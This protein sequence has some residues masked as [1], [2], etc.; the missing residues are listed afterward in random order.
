MPSITQWPI[1]ER[2]QFVPE[3]R[4]ERLD[5]VRLD[6]LKRYPVNARGTVVGFGKRIRGRTSPRSARTNQPSP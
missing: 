1:A 4:E 3:L 5:P 6:C 2:D